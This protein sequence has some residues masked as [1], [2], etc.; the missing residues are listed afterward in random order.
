MAASIFTHHLGKKYRRVHAERALTL[1]E[2]VASG[3]RGLRQKTS[4]V[5]WALRDVNFKVTAGNMVGVIGANGAGKSTLLKLLGGVVQPDEG[6][7]TING[8]LSALIDLGAGFHGDLSGRD[9]LFINA[10]IS[11]LTREET[12]AQFDSIV[13]FAEL[14]KSIDNP[15][16]T[17]SSGMQLRLAFSIAAHIQPD[18]LLVDEILSV[19]DIRFQKKCIQRIEEFKAGGSAILLVSHDIG[20]VRKLCDEVIWLREGSVAAHGPA[21]VVVQQYINAMSNENGEDQSPHPTTDSNSTARLRRGITRFGSAEV[22]ITQVR[23]LDREGREVESIQCGEAL[24]LR[25]DYRNL[26]G[27]RGVVFG[28]TI[29][30]SGGVICFDTSTQA[31]R[32][33]LD[34]LPPTGTLQ[35]D[36]ERLDLMDGNYIIDVGAYSPDWQTTYD[37]HWNVYTLRIHSTKGEKGVYRPPHSWQIGGE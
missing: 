12:R 5:F 22:E 3:F 35:L 17:Y 30:T 8:R 33:T 31:A 14:D 19:G 34:R 27:I 26:L 13:S 32:L 36:F 37:Y 15:L 20:M 1:Q 25:L 29:A 28:V 9:N 4:E 2:A 10:I 21:A 16:R 7:L 24:S 11:G 18:I 6:T 23:L